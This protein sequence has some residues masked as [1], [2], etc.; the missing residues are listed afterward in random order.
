[1]PNNWRLNLINKSSGVILVNAFSR[2][3]NLKNCFEAIKISN[4]EFGFPM[5]VVRQLG[6]ANVGEVIVYPTELT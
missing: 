2:P 1:M 6:N 4:F 5:I 3:E